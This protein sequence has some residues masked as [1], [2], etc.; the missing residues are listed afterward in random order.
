MYWLAQQA[1]KLGSRIAL[2]TDDTQW[3][4]AQ[5][6]ERVKS[7]A[8]VLGHQQLGNQ[9][10]AIL[11]HNDVDLIC[12]IHALSYIAAPVVLLN[13]RLSSVELAQQLADLDV[14]CLFHDGANQQLAQDTQ[15]QLHNLDIH[16]LGISGIKLILIAQ[17]NALVN[18]QINSQINALE[19]HSLTQNSNHSYHLN[20]DDL[21]HN[22]GLT[23]GIFFT[24][25][26]SGK[27]KAVPL[28][29]SNH[30]HSVQATAKH[31]GINNQDNWLLC[32]PLFHVGGLSILWRSV[33]LG[34]GIVLLPRFSVT[35]VFAALATKNI[36]V[37]S[38]VPTLLFRLLA[39]AALPQYL[40]YLQNLKCLLLGGAGTDPKLLQ[41]CQDL[42]IPICPTYGMTEASSQI[43]TLLPHELA[44]KFGSS[45]RPLP[46]NEV[47]ICQGELNKPEDFSENTSSFPNLFANPLTIG[48]IYIR[49]GNVFTGYLLNHNSEILTHDSESHSQT[50]FATGD[51][52]YLDQDGYLYVLNRRHDLII[53]G[54]EN[55]YPIDIETILLRHPAITEACVIGVDH[56]E[57]GQQVV[58]II[59]ATEPL[60][61][62]KIQEFCV[63]Q[64][65]GR[66]KL[67]K[68]LIQWDNLPK[69]ATGK[70]S[71]QI[72]KALIKPLVT[73]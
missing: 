25:G 20:V 39:D 30:W 32:L 13:H 41:R 51:M 9:R 62:T 22:L 60:T 42:Q 18:S 70:L 55:I 34:H 19:K 21:S 40:P 28:S 57:W 10:C 17:I 38:L 46:C 24:S 11:S 50:W 16:D 67:P 37:A 33:I 15:A 58:A 43:T 5:L 72:L 26:T 44:L 63:S 8:V 1:A 3:T 7:W 54:G 65:L 59:V 47:K 27:P 56:H 48:E 29:Y 14:R 49:G 23:Q 36:T 68:Q 31:L 6:H 35:E 71:R 45:G 64:G 69:T 73:D 66:Y 4:F 2:A 53:S 12:L 52:G 61:M